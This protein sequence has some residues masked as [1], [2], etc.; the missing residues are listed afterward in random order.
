MRI[1]VALQLGFCALCLTLLLFG[2]GMY[3]YI[4]FHLNSGKGV[5]FIHLTRN[6][7]DT[8]SCIF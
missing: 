5:D 2:D 7:Y 4:L 3:V 6:L 1:E 8:N